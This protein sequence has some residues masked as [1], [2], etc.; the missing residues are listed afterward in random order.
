[1]APPQARAGRECG[2][3]AGGIAGSAALIA[4]LAY[5]FVAEGSPPG[6]QLR[7]LGWGAAVVF[8]AALAGKAVGIARA[9]RAV[10][11]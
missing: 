9:R 4:Y 8:A 6:W 7:D 3:E 11:G 1:M 2:C 10:E 5:L